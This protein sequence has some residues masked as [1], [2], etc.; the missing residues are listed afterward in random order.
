M[1]NE[2][3]FILD[4]SG[5]MSGI[6]SDTIGGYNAFLE[7]QRKDETPTSV[8]TI[9]FDD[10]YE[11]L[12]DVKDIQEVK[13]IT[14]KEYYVR[15]STALLDAIGK[16][17]NAA[18][19]RI[20]NRA[21]SLQAENV[22]FVIITDGMENASTEYTYSSVKELIQFQEREHKWEFLFLGA[23][24]KSS[25]DADMM[26]FSKKKQ[27]YYSKVRTTE[28]FDCMSDSITDFKMNGVLNETWAED[29][30]ENKR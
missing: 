7:K 17:I 28:V 25:K 30:D 14:E 10:R 20:I 13:N 4:R 2:I 6:E 3:F 23:D 12:H 24:L 11:I 15:G 9:L 1:K 27:A 29:I 8:S 19:S 5:S 16:T 22:I 21:K 18:R 26:G